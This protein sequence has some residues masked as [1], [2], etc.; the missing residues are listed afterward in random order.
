MASNSGKAQRILSSPA[1]SITPSK[2]NYDNNRSADVDLI[3]RFLD[4][5]IIKK[6]RGYIL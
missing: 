1:R 4:F 3:V 5:Q 2:F 6:K